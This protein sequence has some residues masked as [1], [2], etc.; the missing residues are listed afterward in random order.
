[1]IILRGKWPGLGR[2]APGL[3]WVPQGGLEGIRQGRAFSASMQG[4][5]DKWRADL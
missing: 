1:M 3:E 4:V 2:A 5:A